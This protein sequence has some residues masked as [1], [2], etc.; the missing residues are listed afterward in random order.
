MRPSERGRPCF[1]VR[2]LLPGGAGAQYAAL[3]LVEAVSDQ[4]ANDAV[5]CFLPARPPAPVYRMRRA[6][7]LLLAHYMPWRPVFRSLR[8][9]L[10]ADILLQEKGWDG[11]EELEG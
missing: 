6:Q 8:Q 7:G 9:L 10:H 3:P 11:Q 5:C 4:A 2:V 1:N